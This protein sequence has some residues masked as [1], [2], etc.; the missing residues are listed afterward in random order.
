[1]SVAIKPI[2]N[3]S[4]NVK[5]TS[6]N[7]DMDAM[8]KRAIATAFVNM[9]DRQLRELAYVSS[10]DENRDRRHKNTMLSTFYAL[11]VVASVS[12]GLLKEV[13]GNNILSKKLG[14]TGKTAMF[15]GFGLAMLGVYNIVRDAV[16]SN[17]KGLK[18]FEQNNPIP[19]LIM[20]LA[21]FMGLATLGFRGAAK[22]GEKISTK[23]PKT[24]N[25]I[26]SHVINVKNWLNKTSLN[27]KVL[28]AIREGVDNFKTIMP[29]TAEIGRVL[30]ANSVWI[31]LFAGLIKSS[32]H[33]RNDRDRVEKNYH[34]L[35]QAQFETAKDLNK[36]L[37][38]ERD[39]LAQDSAIAKEMKTEFDKELD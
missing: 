36:I 30:I 9:S 2:G 29:I 23:F 27:K 26:S 1:M 39:V 32:N 21:V 31:L 38:I 34:D 18:K 10:Y 16:V 35:K 22:V 17:S 14:A 37:E 24:L 5:F 12:S 19:S 11:P 33:A 3:K 28:P 15:W 13:K 8:D 4:S 6:K 7:D 25:E 20:D